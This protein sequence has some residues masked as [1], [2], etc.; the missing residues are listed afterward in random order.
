MNYNLFDLA[1]L[2][3]YLDGDGCFYLGKTIQ[4]PKSIVVYEYSIQVLSVK[5]PI[6]EWIKTTF[7]G[8]TRTKRKRPKH[9]IPY[10]WTIKGQSAGIIAELICEH[11]VDKRK[12]CKIFITFCKTIF[13]NCGRKI[14]TKLIRQRDNF[15]N[16]IREQRHM[17]DFI[18]KESIDSL[19]QKCNRIDPL[20]KDYAYLAGLI[21]SEGCFRVKKWKPKNKPNSVY[22]IHLEI[23]NTKLP[24]I[25][26]LY[27][28]FGGHIT[29]VP[30]KS[31]RKAYA[32]WSLSAKA[33]F[34]I[35]PKI[36]PFLRSK[37]DIC[38]KLIEFQ[39]TILPNGGDRHSELFNSLFA[40]T[41][42]KRES[43]IQE[44][45]KLNAKGS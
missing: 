9:R 8:F 22:A 40:K 27:E 3:G 32:I 12:Q 36:Y 43:I 31:R 13:P 15:I 1:Y 6:L 7:G 2:S 4:K 21:D 38:E 25:P 26:W 39:N 17:H 18:N 14:Q 29:F 16:K 41:I 11:L 42:A 24:I 10:T 35:L 19:K 44:I 34:D 33:L 28:R 30:E 37:K 5:V 45:H 20:P 23:G